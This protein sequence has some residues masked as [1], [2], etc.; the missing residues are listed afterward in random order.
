MVKITLHFLRLYLIFLVVL[1]IV[2][3]IRVFSSMSAP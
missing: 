2:K 3:A 1:V